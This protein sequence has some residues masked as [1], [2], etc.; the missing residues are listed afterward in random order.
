MEYDLQSA[1]QRAL[2][3]LKGVTYSNADASQTITFDK[4]Y[5]DDVWFTGYIG[6]GYIKGKAKIMGDILQVNDDEKGKSF[7]PT[8]FL[9][10]NDLSDI[11]IGFDYADGQRIEI[12]LP[13]K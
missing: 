13:K 7:Q 10:R 11:D 6:L 8:R 12:S 9:L 2:N 5:G 1:G 4:Q 3:Q